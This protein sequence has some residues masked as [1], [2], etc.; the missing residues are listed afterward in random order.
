MAK[1]TVEKTAAMPAVKFV[2]V[3]IGGQSYALAFKLNAI[4]EAERITGLDLLG[5]VNALIKGGMSFSQF[6]ALLYA[7]LQKAHGPGSKGPKDA[8]VTLERAGDLLEIA[9]EEG[10]AEDVREAL[11]TSYG[12]SFERTIPPAADP[13]AEEKSGD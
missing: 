10:T 1:Q 7:G 13:P 2:P 8:G 5:G 11:M 4:A 3:T 9:I 12:V 6:R